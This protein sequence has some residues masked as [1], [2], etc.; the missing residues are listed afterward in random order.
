MHSAESGHLYQ[1]T[2][3]MGLPS[4]DFLPQPV[5]IE[6]NNPR[7]LPSPSAS[8]AAHWDLPQHGFGEISTTYGSNS[9]RHFHAENQSRASSQAPLI[10]WYTENDGPW[11]PKGVIPEER[12]SKLKIGNRMSMQYGNQYR[13]LK[14]SDS[15]IYPFGTPNSDSGYG[16]N[17]ARRSDGNAS[18]FSADLTDKDQDSHSIAGPTSDFHSYQGINEVLQPSDV[19]RNGPWSTITSNPSLGATASLVCPTCH[20]GV[21]TPSEL[22]CGNLSWYREHANRL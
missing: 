8:A 17:G 13:Q 18:I 9:A 11:V 7:T 3:G 21:K 5:E 1:S 6:L 20:K 10:Q 19:P 16:S 22:K 4:M 12:N 14:S 15:G 2:R